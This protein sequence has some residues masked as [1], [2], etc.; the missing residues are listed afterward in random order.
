MGVTC[1]PEHGGTWYF[2]KM[3]V[4]RAGKICF[5]VTFKTSQ[6]HASTVAMSMYNDPIPTRPV[7]LTTGGSIVSSILIIYLLNIFYSHLEDPNIL[8]GCSYQHRTE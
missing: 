8:V 3:V 2:L 5:K 4:G 6:G 1:V 7:G